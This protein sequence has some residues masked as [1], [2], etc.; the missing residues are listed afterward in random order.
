MPLAPPVGVV[1]INHNNSAFVERAIASVQRQTVRDLR[2]VV[3]DDASTDGSE[4]VIRRALADLEDS[5]FTFVRLETNIGQTAALARGLA[6]LD[7]PF[8]AVLDS[9][10][11]WY[12]T[13]VARHL[14]CQLNSDFPVG[15][16]YSDSHLI[17]G[18]DR[19]LAGT[20]WWFDSSEPGHWAGRDIDANLRP[21][22]DPAT[23]T[24]NWPARPRVTFHPQWSIDGATNT[25][26]GMM[27]RR[28]FIDLVLVP[29]SEQLRLYADYYLSTFAGLLTGAIAIHQPLYA[30]RMHGANKHSNATV[31]GGTYNS[32]TRE[33]G[34]IRDYVLLLV[35]EVL[36]R[37]APAIRAAFGVQRHAEAEALLAGA[38]DKAA[39][40]RTGGARSSPWLG[41]LAAGLI[42]MGLARLGLR[43][44][45]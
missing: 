25:M 39:G 19:L 26:S 6:F 18:D 30:Y 7:T 28:A 12:E 42:G 17:D 16:T 34:P 13:F 37:E 15:L 44:R 24:L 35:Q 21:V 43:G 32:S 22:F 20:A 11:V 23:G 36:A 5:R 8:V 27:F 29:P 41:E 2:V 31:L 33:W 3:V 14:E 45:S 10:D 38:V 40:R 4:A 9:D 1:V